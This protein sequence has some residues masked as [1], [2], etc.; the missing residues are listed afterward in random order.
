MFRGPSCAEMRVYR[1]GRRE[2]HFMELTVYLRC[3]QT[4]SIKG[5]LV[6]IFSFANQMVSVAITPL[7]HCSVKA[8]TDIRKTNGQTVTI[9]L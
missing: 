7:C 2:H 1:D 4:F 8:A 5:Q 6:N 3:W 9:K